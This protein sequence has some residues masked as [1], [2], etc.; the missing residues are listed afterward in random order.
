MYNVQMPKFGM[1]MESGEISEWFVKEGDKVS[2][3]QALC[4]ISSEKITNSLECY[5][6]G[7]ID[8][9]LVEEGAEAAIGD[10]IATIIED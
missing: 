6:D 8:K 4:E 2:K 1:T 3:G 10:V 9:I 7:K 5:T